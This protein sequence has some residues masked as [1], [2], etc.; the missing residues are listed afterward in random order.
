LIR[1]EFLDQIPAHALI[2]D[3]NDIRLFVNRVGAESAG[4]TAEE[5]IERPC[6]AVSGASPPA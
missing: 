3:E 2:L 6:A 4:C 5:I 1:H